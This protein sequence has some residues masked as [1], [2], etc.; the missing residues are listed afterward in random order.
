MI[1]EVQSEERID[2]F[3]SLLGAKTQHRGFVTLTDRILHLYDDWATITGGEQ[4][5]CVI[6]TTE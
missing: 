5:K 3:K 6:H 1:W 2:V 4:Q